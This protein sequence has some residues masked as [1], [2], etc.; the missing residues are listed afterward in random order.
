M[1]ALDSEID[2]NAIAIHD[3][4]GDLPKS[5][6]VLSNGKK[7]PQLQCMDPDHLC[8]NRTIYVLTY[9]VRADHL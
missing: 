1:A 8:F 7:Y 5:V 6:Y 3:A 9:V 4:E 2:E